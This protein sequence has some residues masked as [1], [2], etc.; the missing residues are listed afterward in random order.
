MRQQPSFII[1]LTNQEWRHWT[2][3][4]GNQTMFNQL[5]LTCAFVDE[6]IP[7]RHASQFQYLNEVIHKPKEPF[8]TDA[9]VTS[10][11]SYY[12]NRV[13]SDGARTR[14]F[15]D[16]RLMAQLGGEAMLNSFA[17][18]NDVRNF[19][20]TQQP[21]QQSRQVLQQQQ[22]TF[23]FQPLQSHST[24]SNNRREAPVDTED[25]SN[26]ADNAIDSPDLSTAFQPLFNQQPPRQQQPQFA[27]PQSEV[28][29]NHQHHFQHHTGSNNNLRL[30][31]FEDNQFPTEFRA[32]NDFGNARE[33][34]RDFSLQLQQQA[35]QQAQQ[36]QQQRSQ[37]PLSPTA[38]SFDFSIST[39]HQLGAAPDSSVVISNQFRQDQVKPQQAPS[40]TGPAQFGSFTTT[41]ENQPTSTPLNV[42]P[43]FDRSPATTTLSNNQ[44]HLPTTTTTS[45]TPT[46]TSFTT[47]RPLGFES[48]FQPTTQ[49]SLAPPTTSTASST[50]SVA[51]TTAATTNQPAPITTTTSAS[52]FAAPTLT[53]TERQSHRRQV[54]SD[55]RS[56]RSQSSR[57]QQRNNQNNNLLLFDQIHKPFQSTRLSAQ[58]RQAQQ[59]P[60]VVMRRQ[61]NSNQLTQPLA[62]V[63]PNSASASPTTT[64]RDSSSPFEGGSNSFWLRPFDA[65]FMAPRFESLLTRR[66]V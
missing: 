58:R 60:A 52:S 10:G 45:T 39:N 22:P 62:G 28:I 54:V 44:H 29:I 33:S 8:L 24:F 42:A 1:R 30:N 59:E 47:N 50:T 12:S 37:T 38:S 51:A 53:S 15:R 27:N 13:M 31:S 41:T 2:Y 55:S 25:G 43:P 23:F 63:V 11:I 57:Q 17:S 36:Q 19:Q 32:T 21:R 18:S 61:A 34:R 65:Q 48:Q 5:T 6:A 16:S 66:R 46:T 26:R 64:L 35:Q 3:A 40:A 49:G 4:C 7:C 9:D 14:A 56:S 20:P